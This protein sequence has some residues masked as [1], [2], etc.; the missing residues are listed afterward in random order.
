MIKLFTDSAAYIPM[1]MIIENDIQVLQHTLIVEGK[2]VKENKIQYDEFYANIDKT[3]TLPQTKPLSTEEM[4]PVFENEIKQ[5]NEVLIILISSKLSESYANIVEATKMIKDRYSDAVI[6]VVDSKATCMEL[7]FAVLA[8]AQKIKENASFANAVNAARET[9]QSTRGLFIPQ[10]LKYLEIDGRIT[11]AQA[12]MGDMVRVAPIL[13]SHNGS[14]VLGEN[15]ISKNR[16]ITKSLEMLKNDIDK[17]GIKTIAVQHIDDFTEANKLVS[18]V[19]EITDAEV[20]ISEIGPI[21][22]SR[23]GPSTLSL[24]YLTERPITA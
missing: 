9:I 23:L 17:F 12:I 6:Q 21:V 22:G 16:A 24:A 11:K 8:A 7:G 3:K 20:L 18:K 13:N 19:K 4:Y 10:R 14:L 1:D 5:G 15:N 2:E